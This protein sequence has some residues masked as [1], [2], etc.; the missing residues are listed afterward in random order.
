[1]DTLRNAIDQTV[2]FLPALVSGLV[3]LAIGCII[4]LLVSRLVRAVLPRIG[5]DRFLVRHKLTDRSPETRPG[6][7]LVAAAA[8]WVVVLVALMQAANIWGLGFVATGLAAAIAYL[9][10]V[11]A[12]VLI[13]GAA[14][15]F[16]NWVRE[17]LR[18]S[19]AARSSGAM[20]PEAVR[21]GVLTI[22][23]FMALRQLLIAPEILVIAFTLVFG[24]IAV[25]TALAFGLGGRRTAERMTEEWYERRRIGRRTVPTPPAERERV[26]FGESSERPGIH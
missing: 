2:A 7:N 11:V 5:F 20:L 16:G 14:F 15:V 19:S 3:V 26:E 25:A 13:F 1:M 18:A 10:N 12:A 6:S 8:A 22:A 9:P 17:R 24:A 4:A 21:A 23:A